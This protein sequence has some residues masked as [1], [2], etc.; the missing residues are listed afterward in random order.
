MRVG[1]SGVPTAS[2]ASAPHNRRSYRGNRI[3]GAIR[4]ADHTILSSRLAG[5]E[6]AVSVPGEQ[7]ED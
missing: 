2:V 1:Q 6:L 7:R 5:S 4:M 3:P